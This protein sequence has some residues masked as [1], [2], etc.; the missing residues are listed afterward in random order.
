MNIVVTDGYTLNPGDLSWNEIEELGAITVYERTAPSELAAR[1]REAEVLLTNKTPVDAAAMA[2]LPRLRYIG[3]LATGYNVVDLAGAARRGVVVTNIPAYST[4]SVAQLAF[5]LILELCHHVQ[6]HSES[7][8]SGDWSRSKDFSY[9]RFPLIELAGKTLGILGY[10]QI[11]RSVAR[12]ARAFGMEVIAAARQAQPAQSEA[13]PGRAPSACEEA[14]ITRVPRA[15]LFRLSDVVCL[16]AP[17]TPE[18]AGVIDRS[19]LSLMKRSAFL[20][21]VS[22]GGLVV[23][24]D[25][26]EALASGR[27]AGAGLDVL[28]E[29]PPR[30]DN[31][32]LSAP[33]CIV[34]PHIAW[35]T[36][37]ARSRAMAIAAA[38]LRAFL[39]GAPQNV[40]SGSA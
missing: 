31:P 25:L 26:A 5:A 30:A 37:E 4:P 34:T 10:G 13:A 12:I 28:A 22:R 16:T 21:N 35:A 18:T 39:A 20:I 32:L 29:E 2:L 27:I 24:A 38:N 11:G 1:A 33:G 8:R 36:R 9:R 23:E 15:E 14:P 3:V 19:A 40:V 7:V 6:A 17:L